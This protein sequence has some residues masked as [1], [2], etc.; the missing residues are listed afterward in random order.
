MHTQRGL[1]VTTGSIE[2]VDSINY[3][4]EQILSSGQNA[5]QSLDSAKKHTDNLL[6]QT[7]AA[8]FYLYA[9]EDVANEQA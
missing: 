2:A 8:A 7:Y 1:E 9:Q 5:I 6:I 4:H 3:F